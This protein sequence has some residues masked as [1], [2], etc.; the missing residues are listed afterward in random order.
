M[1]SRH[2]NRKPHRE[3]VARARLWGALLLI[4]TAFFATAGIRSR[5]AASERASE[6][7][8]TI[9]AHQSP[10]LDPLGP[11]IARADTDTLDLQLD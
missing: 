10:A 9:P 2:S 8:S 1:N 7:P 6:K 11:G 5:P 4:V 3:N